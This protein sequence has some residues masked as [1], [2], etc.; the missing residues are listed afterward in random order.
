MVASKQN[1]DKDQIVT[2][3]AAHPTLPLCMCAFECETDVSPDLSA[4]VHG[5]IFLWHFGWNNALAEFSFN[6]NPDAKATH[7][8]HITRS[9]SGGVLHVTAASGCDST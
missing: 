3:L 9:I 5:R 8:D 7:P 1:V 4:N 2:S 6:V